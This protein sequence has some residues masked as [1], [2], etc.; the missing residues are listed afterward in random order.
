MAT[1]STAKAKPNRPGPLL[2]DEWW[3]IWVNA[4]PVAAILLIGLIA[5]HIATLIGY[6]L[7]GVG[8]PDLK[9]AH[10]NGAFL[11]NSTEGDV[12]GSF[13]NGYIVHTIDG[14]A[15]AVLFAALVRSKLTFLKNGILKGV[16]YGLLLGIIS[17]GFLIP[18][19]YA[20]KA[21]FGLFSF[22]DNDFGT[23]PDHWKLPFAVLLWHAIYGGI[24][25]Q[26]Y[27]GTED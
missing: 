17:I 18:Y 11:G 22:G 19:V 6:Y 10:F 24:I 12:S 1:K 26:L 13:I 15:F 27:K 2:P 8:L 14:I 9:W 23:N 7:P 4:H 25:G 3:R 21:G 20:P 16:F 5:T